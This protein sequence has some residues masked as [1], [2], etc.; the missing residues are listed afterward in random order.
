M[1]FDEERQKILVFQNKKKVCS[2]SVDDVIFMC[3]KLGLQVER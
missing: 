3:T 1:R 2:F